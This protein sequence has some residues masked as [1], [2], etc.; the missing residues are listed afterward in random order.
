MVPCCSRDEPSPSGPTPRAVVVSVEE[1]YASSS[2][3]GLS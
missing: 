2:Y 1:P 3:P